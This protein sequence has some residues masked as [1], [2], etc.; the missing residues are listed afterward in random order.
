MKGICLENFKNLHYETQLLES[1]GWD[2]SRLEALFE[3]LNSI[4]DDEV[5]VH[6]AHVLQTIEECFG[7]EVK[8]CFQKIFNEITVTHNLHNIEAL[9]EH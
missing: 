2:N 6:P 5:L 4:F 7:E 1:L 8:I 3:Y 9:N